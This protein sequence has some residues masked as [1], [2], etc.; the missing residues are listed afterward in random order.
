MNIWPDVP[1]YHRIADWT[2]S[3]QTVCGREIGVYKPMIPFKH[4]KKIG[5]PCKGC[6]D[7]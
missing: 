6:F 2:H 1:V 7:V 5:R 4:V 3:T